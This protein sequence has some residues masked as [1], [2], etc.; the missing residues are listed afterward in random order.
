MQRHSIQIRAACLDDE[1]GELKEI[2][3]IL[4]EG[5]ELMKEMGETPLET[6]Y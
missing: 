5:A 4:T 1:Q 3:R 2:S 6:G